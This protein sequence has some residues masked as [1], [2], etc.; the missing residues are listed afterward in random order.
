MEKIIV[1]YPNVIE[2]LN[3]LIW[4]LY[5]NDYF[6]FEE[7]AHEYVKR[8]KDAIYN[9]LLILK[10]YNTPDQL[11]PYGN[12]YVKIKGSKRTMWYVFFDK[13]KNRFLIQFITNNHTP[14]SEFLNNL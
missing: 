14:Q 6:I 9:D 1:V 3:K 8:L 11:K 2:Y 12:Y 5:N 7:N 4:I 10:H 13:N